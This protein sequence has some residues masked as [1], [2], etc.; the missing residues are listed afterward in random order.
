MNYTH[1]KNQLNS[2]VSGRSMIEMLG[3]LSI[4][5]ALTIGG[6][7]GYRML[8]NRI[9]ADKVRDD[10]ERMYAEII[11][12]KRL[13]DAPL[14]SITITSGLTFKQE[15]VNRDLLISAQNVSEKL[16]LA[17][18]DTPLRHSIVYANQK[19]ASTCESGSNNTV[20][21]LFEGT[22]F[23][24][25]SGSSSGGGSD[26][27]NPNPNPGCPDVS[28]SDCVYLAYGDDGCLKEFPITEGRCQNSSNCYCT[29]FG[30]EF[31]LEN[32]KVND[33]LNGCDCIPPTDTTCQ[34]PNLINGC[35]D[36]TKVTCSG[37][38][39]LCSE[40]GTCVAC[41]TPTATTC[42]TVTN[43]ENGCPTALFVSCTSNQTCSEAGVCECNPPSKTSCFTEQKDTDGC[44]IAQ[45]IE[46]A[47][48]EVCGDNEQCVVM[49]V[50]TAPSS[51]TIS[52]LKV[53]ENTTFQVEYSV[54]PAE[55]A[56]TFALSGCP[57]E[58]AI[59]S[60]TGVISW[61][62]TATG[63]GSCQV[64][65][66]APYTSGT[67]VTLQYTIAANT[68]NCGTHS[69]HQASNCREV[70]GD[71]ASR[72]FP[73]FTPEETCDW[74]CKTSC[75]ASY[76][77]PYTC[78]EG[79]C[80]CVDVL[81]D[82]QGNEKFPYCPCLAEGTLIT[83][84]NGQCKLIEDIDY[85][86]TLRVWDFDNAC[87][88]AAKPCFIKIEQ[89]TTQYNLLR[90]DDGSELKTI[91]QHRIFNKEAGKFTYPMTEETPVGTT[92]FNA[93][94]QEIKLLSKEVVHETVNFYNIITERHFNCF[95]NGILTS[96][97]LNNL[98]PIANM[99]FVKDNRPLLTKNNFP[100][101][102][103]YWFDTLRIAEQPVAIN[104]GNDDNHGDK[105]ITDYV[106]RM[107]HLDKRC[108]NLLL[109]AS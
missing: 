16:C 70:A 106:N 107:I 64:S 29:S 18:K 102:A 49:P 67:Q 17:L 96:C 42:S 87:F 82:N 36:K 54:T 62:P 63:S 52:N 22:N 53:N 109:K 99:Q 58:A 35:P 43:D 74:T 21:Y 69:W 78:T 90:F 65:L 86:D 101:I 92:T 23:R 91:S 10:V 85:T 19:D 28:N 30:P 14:S 27:D 31:C 47:A 93:A 105:T 95:A 75:T 61:T 68:G 44:V 40:D 55:T 12:H 38:T 81:T 103:S 1:F 73:A 15:V 104:R 89:T 66:T 41:P 72:C 59:N 4:A 6:L 39:P 100:K 83:L 97:R 48:G 77:R 26:P 45:K 2:S 80:S 98:Y 79:S 33:S 32:Q 3:V 88:A 5:G 37:T 108:Q 84:E 7:T 76:T 56:V 71:Q 25:G 57:S 13:E 20:Y 11:L 24:T 34:E 8:L 94:G 60:S 50:I 51:Q 46:C 9:Q